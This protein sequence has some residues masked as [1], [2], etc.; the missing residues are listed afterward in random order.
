MCP[1]KNATDIQVTVGRKRLLSPDSYT[2]LRVSVCFEMQNE[3]IVS[4]IIHVFS[5]EILSQKICKYE[6]TMI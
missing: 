6:C 3:G 4:V 5:R 2:Y 1:T